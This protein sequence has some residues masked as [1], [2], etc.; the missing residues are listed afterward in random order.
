VHYNY[1]D[2]GFPATEAPGLSVFTREG[3]QVFH[4]YSVFSR[5]LD[6]FNPAYQLLD[7]VPKGRDEAGLDYSMAWLRRRD[8]YAD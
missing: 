5:G 2:A 8:Q 6:L 3:D 7:L 4:T 1:R